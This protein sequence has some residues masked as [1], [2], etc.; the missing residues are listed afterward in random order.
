MNY[1]FKSLSVYCNKNDS[2]AEAI[3]H[4]TRHDTEKFE[5]IYICNYSTRITFLRRASGLIFMK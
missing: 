4:L 5:F 1:N 3:L 2:I